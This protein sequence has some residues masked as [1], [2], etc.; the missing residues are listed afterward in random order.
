MTVLRGGETILRLGVAVVTGGMAAAEVISAGGVSAIEGGILATRIGGAA[1]SGVAVVGG[2]L[3][4]AMMPISI[5]D[6]ATNAYRLSHHSPTAAVENIE[7]QL[8]ELERQRKEINEV[9][10]SEL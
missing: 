8:K 5:Y 6:L 4:V 1:L 2:V 3:T 7:K 10:E 9:F